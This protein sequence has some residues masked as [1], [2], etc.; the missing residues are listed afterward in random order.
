LER[1]EV[2]N[3]L[4]SWP[5]LDETRELVGVAINNSFNNLLGYPS[6]RKSQEWSQFISVTREEL[7]RIFEKWS[8]RQYR[9]HFD[10]EGT[11]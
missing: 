7:A 6:R 9:K 3:I 10:G 2:N 1:D 4:E 5:N 11:S 8:G